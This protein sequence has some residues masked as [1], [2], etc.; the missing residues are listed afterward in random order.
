MYL[1]LFDDAH[2]PTLHSC[3][4]PTLNH[5]S[6]PK[7]DCASDLW[8]PY[9]WTNVELSSF[10]PL[11]NVGL[12][13]E[14]DSAMPHGDEDSWH[15]A[16]LLEALNCT[17]LVT[18]FIVLISV[19]VKRSSHSVV[20]A[21]DKVHSVQVISPKCDLGLPTISDGKLGSQQGSWHTTLFCC[22][23][24]PCSIFFRPFKRSRIPKSVV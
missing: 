12:I 21:A 10:G 1:L 9:A 4:T 6:E 2:V 18:R 19:G 15:S 13:L 7:S 24:V 23:L 3:P 14:H 20:S 16:G 17:G 5:G 8:A 11:F 22:A